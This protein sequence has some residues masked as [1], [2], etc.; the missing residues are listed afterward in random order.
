MKRK[1]VK[2]SF[3]EIHSLL[4]VTS[5]PGR[6]EIES[7]KERATRL[8]SDWK[9]API[10][11]V[12][13]MY[14]KSGHRNTHSDN[15]DQTVFFLFPTCLSTLNFLPIWAASLF[16]SHTLP[17]AVNIWASPL[18]VFPLLFSLSQHMGKTRKLD[19]NTNSFT[20][21]TNHLYKIPLRP[22]ITRGQNIHIVCS[23]NK[24]KFECLGL[25]GEEQP[26]FINSLVKVL[27]C[28]WFF[29]ISLCCLIVGCSDLFWKQ[30]ESHH[31][32]GLRWLCRQ[33]LVFLPFLNY[34]RGTPFFSWM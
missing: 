5:H 9:N 14:R 34:I 17:S 13:K 6:N 31:K 20:Y 21:S 30:G 12:L 18:H 11:S 25:P 16:L 10:F 23:K 15:T 3:L 19:R 2:N 1:N 26:L 28:C 4:W 24:E 7:T 32:Q 8:T 29:C 33:V 27:V 22:Q